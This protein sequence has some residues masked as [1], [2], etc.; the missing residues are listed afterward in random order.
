MFIIYT[1]W[2]KN[3][4]EQNMDDNDNPKLY[5]EPLISFKL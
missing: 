3:L 2:N 1:N 5:D 4:M